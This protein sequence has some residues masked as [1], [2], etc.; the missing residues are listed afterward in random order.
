MTTNK[1]F[2]IVTVVGCL[3]CIGLGLLTIILPAIIPWS[4]TGFD[5]LAD[6]LGLFF[7]LFG[8]TVLLAGGLAVFTLVVLKQLR[9]PFRIVGCLPGILAGLGVVLL[10][11]SMFL[12]RYLV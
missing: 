6:A 4:G 5:A 7:C 1:T 9:W 3:L 2:E 8:G 12:P 11:A 10:L